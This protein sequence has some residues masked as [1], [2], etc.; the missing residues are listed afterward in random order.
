MGEA[1]ALWVAAAISAGAATH[2]GIEANKQKK[3]QKVMGKKAED[4]QNQLANEAQA[5]QVREDSLAMNKKERDLAKLNA[6]G[7][8]GRE[9]TILTGPSGLSSSPVTPGKTLLGV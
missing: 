8:T 3:E 2:Q 4:K 1:A 9:S 6:L 5:A 7:K